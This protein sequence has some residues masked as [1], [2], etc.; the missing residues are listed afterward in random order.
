MSKGYGP[1]DARQQIFSIKKNCQNWLNFFLVLVKKE[2]NS[3]C[4]TTDKRKLINYRDGYVK[5]H[6]GQIEVNL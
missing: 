1:K 2:K 6:V 3:R 4:Q 5:E